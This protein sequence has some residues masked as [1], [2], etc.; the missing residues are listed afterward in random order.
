MST[1]VT[2]PTD[3]VGARKFASRPVNGRSSRRTFNA[4]APGFA[5]NTGLGRDANAFLRFV[6]NYILPLRIPDPH[7]TAGRSLYGVQPFLD[8]E[9]QASFLGD[10]DEIAKMP[11]FHDY[12][13]PPR[14]THLL[15]K[16]IAEAPGPP[17][18]LALEAREAPIGLISLPALPSILRQQEVRNR[19]EPE[20]ERDH[21]NANCNGR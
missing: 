5:P 18:Y 13:M 9:R 10:G 3:P 14:H 4:L 8:R 16:S 1:A 2:P 20:R 19:E 7:L 17:T 6:A 11:Q 12:S 21:E 15:T